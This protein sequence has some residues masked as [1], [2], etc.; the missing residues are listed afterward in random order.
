MPLHRGMSRETVSKNIRE[1]RASG[2]PQ[3]QAVAIAFETARRSERAMAT[4]KHRKHTKHKTKKHHVKKHHVKRKHHTKH[5]HHTKSKKRGGK[6]PLDVLK[7]FYRKTE[8]KQAGLKK[9]IR[10]RGG[11]V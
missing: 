9:L 10:A 1:L 11:H 8:R 2:Y 4:R 7:H 5:K 6:R 3:K